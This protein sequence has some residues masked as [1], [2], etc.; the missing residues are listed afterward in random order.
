VIRT[1][2]PFSGL[3]SW[4]PLFCAPACCGAG[5]ST[6][7]DSSWLESCVHFRATRPPSRGRF[8]PEC[9][10]LSTWASS[11]HEIAAANMGSMA[12]EDAVVTED[13]VNEALEEVIDPELGLDF[14]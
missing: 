11:K 10:V 3:V 5:I 12:T 8:T 4:S 2:P 14:V 7:S 6:I 1:A 9:V 13:D